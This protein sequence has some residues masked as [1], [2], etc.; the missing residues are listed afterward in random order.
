MS[1]HTIFTNRQKYLKVVQRVQR[2]DARH[3]TNVE[4][5][6]NVPVIPAGVPDGLAAQEKVRFEGPDYPGTGRRDHYHADGAPLLCARRHRQV[7]DVGLLHVY[8]KVT[9][10]TLAPK[11]SGPILAQ[12]GLMLILPFCFFKVEYLSITLFGKNQIH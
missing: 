2:I 7:L 11:V 3:A 8:L 12:N 1:D 6:Q 4:S 5:Q 10:E 9:K